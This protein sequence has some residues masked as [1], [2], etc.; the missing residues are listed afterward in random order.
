MKLKIWLI[1]FVLSVHVCFG[2]NGRFLIV[3]HP[4]ALKLL[5]AYRQEMS[6]PQKQALGTFVPFQLER[7][8][9][10]GDQVTQAYQ[11]N[12]LGQK[13]FLL[14]N[15]RGNIL[16]LE[17][18]G[19]NKL[20]KNVRV[21]NDTVQIKAGFHLTLIDPKTK[22]SQQELGAGQLMIRI[23]QQ[24]RFIYMATFSLPRMFGF[25]KAP[26]NA[27]WQK[28][29]SKEVTK[30][31]RR[32][33]FLNQLQFIVQEHNQIYRALF[34]YFK[35]EKVDEVLPEWKIIRNNQHINLVFSRPDLLLK[36]PKS[37]KLFVDKI[38]NLA[39]QYDWLC[40]A[41]NPF[42]YQISERSSL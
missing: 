6:V 16:N 30:A 10:L 36:W 3:E 9:T 1:A 31:L 35:G 7:V 13:Y 24:G 23:F 8:I 38:E 33:A 15:A 39:Q 34:Q 17:K 40:K 27:V 42:T 2:Q 5:N 25:L 37:T 21:I 29:R 41:Q 11:A 4:A 20:Y 22:Q 12:V 19:F 18:T 32:N 14:L 28:V 26:L